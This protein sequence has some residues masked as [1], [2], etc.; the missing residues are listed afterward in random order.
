VKEAFDYAYII[1]GHAVSPL[2][3]S[4]PNKDSDSTLGRIIKVTQ[5]VIDYREWIIKKWG[6]RHNARI[7]RNP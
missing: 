6:G 4:Y 1:L 7:E 3:R 5:E 2:A